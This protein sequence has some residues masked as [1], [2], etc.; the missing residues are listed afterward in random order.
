MIDKGA[1]INFSTDAWREY[2]LE[3]IHDINTPEK[4]SRFQRLI[5]SESM[6]VMQ[7]WKNLAKDFKPFISTEADGSKHVQ[8]W[9]E[10]LHEVIGTLIFPPSFTDPI[11]LQ[12]FKKVLDAALALKN[13][14]IGLH[15]V[16]ERG[17]TIAHNSIPA[18]DSIISS[19]KAEISGNTP[20][21]L[22]PGKTHGK[23]A[24]RNWLALYLRLWIIGPFFF[25]PHHEDI[26]TLVNATLNIDSLSADDVRLMKP[27]SKKH[28]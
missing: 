16:D 5:N 27:R 26:A 13:E 28:P 15:L 4:T 22:I 6:N 17:V 19:L 10:S 7:A 11:P 9:Q 18:L 20:H 25:N 1:T 23:N 8:S 21:P 12:K 3:N 14:F 24:E 2:C